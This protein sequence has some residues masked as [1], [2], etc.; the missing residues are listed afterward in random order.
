MDTIASLNL[1][2]ERECQEV[3]ST[4]YGLREFWLQRRALLP[5]YTLGA[6]SYLDAVKV[7]QEYYDKAKCYNS[8]LKEYLE[9]LYKQLAD[10]LSKHLKA[11]VRYLD[12]AGLPGFHIYLA[13]KLFEQPLASVHYDLQYRLLRWECPDQTDFTH[14]LSFTLAISL[15]KFGG[16]LNMWSI[17]HQ[18]AIRMNKAQ[19]KD[20]IKS[21]VKSF[22]PYQLGQ[23]ILH[24]GH[25]LHQAAPAKDIQPEDTR[26]TLQGHALLSQGSW[27][28]YW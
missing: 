25:T 26:I 18:E 1:L 14:P 23:L 3:S 13:H 15:P 7:Q 2:T 19:L 21:R 12:A 10:V 27:Q 16:G 6:A 22:Y 24:S 28:L 9:W 20:L 5:F 11:P 8:I 17:G 4:I